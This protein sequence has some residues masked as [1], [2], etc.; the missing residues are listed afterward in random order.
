MIAYYINLD[1][2]LDRKILIEREFSNLDIEFIR[3][4]AILHS[5][6]A[7]GCLQ[8]HIKVLETCD[9]DADFIWICEDDIEFLHSFC[10]CNIT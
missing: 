4:P 1:Y 5:N 8:S 3:I 7:I 2:R 10:I 6:G 9:P